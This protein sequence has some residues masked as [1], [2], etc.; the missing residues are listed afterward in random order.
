MLSETTRPNIAAA[1]AITITFG[2]LR[3]GGGGGDLVVF[4]GDDL[5]L[6]DATLGLLGRTG[7]DLVA[8]AAG[9]ER[10]D[11]RQLH[12]RYAAPEVAA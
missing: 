11:V 2:P 4:V 1:N 9:S 10:F 6:G 8:R 3:A 5:A 7:A 12:Q